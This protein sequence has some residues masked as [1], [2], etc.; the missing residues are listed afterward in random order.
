MQR[1]LEDVYADLSARE[2]GAPRRTRREIRALVQAADLP[3]EAIDEA[4]WAR[5]RREWLT[6]EDDITPFADDALDARYRAIA[7]QIGL[8]D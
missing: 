4:F 7:M 2:G 8:L 3:W 5:I 1:S 6:G